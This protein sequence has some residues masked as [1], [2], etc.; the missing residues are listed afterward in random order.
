[1]YMNFA[2]VT[3]KSIVGNRCDTAVSNCKRTVKSYN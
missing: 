2:Y 1:M 3:F